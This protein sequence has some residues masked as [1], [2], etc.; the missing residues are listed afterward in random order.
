MSAP[1]PQRRLRRGFGL[2]EGLVAVVILSLGLLGL[3]RWQTSLIAQT[4]ESQSR[5][6]ASTLADELLSTVLVD[7][8]NAACYTLPQTGSCGSNAARARATEWK[9]RVEA[10]L[11]GAAAPIGTLDAATRRFTVTLQWTGKASRDTHQLEMSTDAR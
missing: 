2:L 11:P 5:A 9:T 10:A 1:A 6:H 3:A 8:A 7:T 4:T